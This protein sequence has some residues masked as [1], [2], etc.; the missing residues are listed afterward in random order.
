MRAILALTLAGA[1]L[2]APAVHA[3]APG[4][5]TVVSV[6]P[7]AIVLA[8]SLFDSISRDEYNRRRPT[9]LDH[10]LEFQTGVVV[11]RTGPIGHDARFSRFGI[12]RGRGLLLVDGITMND[13]Q[14]DVAPLVDIPVSGVGT[15]WLGQDGGAGTVRGT[16]IEGIASIVQAPAPQGRPA[17]F[18]G[19]SNGTN[20]LR[21]RRLRVSSAQGRVG[22][23][24]HY[25]EVRND[26][27]PFDAN[28]VVG[29]NVPEFG[30]AAARNTGIA[31]RGVVDDGS[32]YHF[33]FRQ[34]ESSAAGDVTST[35][36][37]TRRS[38]HLAALGADVGPVQL[39]MFGR[40][41]DMSRVDSTT[42]NETVGGYVSVHA[43]RREEVSLALKAGLEQT[44]A[45]QDVGGA[46]SYRRIV[47]TS[48]SM[49]A[50]SQLNPTT[51]GYGHVSLRYQRNVP[52]AWGL[53][54][55][56]QTHRGPHLLSASIER[57][58]RMPNLGELYLPAHARGGSLVRG[59][60][61]AKPESA[62]E[63]WAGATSIL[64]LVHNEVR[65]GLIRVQDPLAY[66]AVL[67]DTIATVM[68][69][70]ASGDRLGVIEENVRV[71]WPW[72]SLSWR[73]DAAVSFTAG[74]REGFFRS[75]PRTRAIASARLGR[76]LFE[77]T[78]ALFFGIEYMYSDSRRDYAGNELPSYG[79]LNLTLD[80]KLL[81]AHLYLKYLNVFN[82]EYRTTGDY[83]MTPRT[84]VYGIAWRL[85]D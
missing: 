3:Q 21:Q 7:P 60:V 67:V 61:D 26:G 49:E 42:V 70:N 13:P 72:L 78:S 22:I 37:E 52:V 59:N 14:T 81:D 27:Y 83:L 43:M 77:A 32:G 39:T 62:W 51:V 8:A 46:S 54:A 85:F 82:E 75:S 30:H 1:G 44:S 66:A 48:A 74:E 2:H 57:T 71:E 45:T 17:T 24:L 65:A 12:G 18:V 19:L 20:A 47:R 23:D 34:F 55:S 69:I 50:T 41:Y 31:V 68:P 73:V 64:G 28:H 29:E 25:D 56:A 63:V 6:R 4:D 38:G 11:S 35:T 5:S 33:S 10:F 80:G 15:L 79:V 40:G 36:R 76:A 58:F 9:S 16:G 53:G 84:F